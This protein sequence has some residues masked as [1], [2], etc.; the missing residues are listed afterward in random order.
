MRGNWIRRT[1]FGLVIAAGVLCVLYAPR[2][3]SPPP[4]LAQEEGSNRYYTAAIPVT[5]A[6]TAGV[7]LQIPAAGRT[8]RI[9]SMTFYYDNAANT[10]TA[11]IGIVQANAGQTRV[12]GTWLGEAMTSSGVKTLSYS[13]M[14]RIAGTTAQAGLR[15]FITAASSDTLDASVEYEVIL[16]R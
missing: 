1:V 16:D 4:V 7:A 8:I 6:D 12:T 3:T 13:P 10:N 2:D 14:I 5:S 9:R 15:L 11:N